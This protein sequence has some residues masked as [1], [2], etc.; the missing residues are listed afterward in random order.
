M[1]NWKGKIFLKSHDLILTVGLQYTKAI[2]KFVPRMLMD[3]HCVTTSQE[4]FKQSNL[5][6]NF[7]NFIVTDYIK[8]GT[9]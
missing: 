9:M 4:L 7:M 2:L 8:K 1:S 5:E 6:K 3:D